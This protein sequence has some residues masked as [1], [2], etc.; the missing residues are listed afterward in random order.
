MGCSY[1][2]DINLYFVYDTQYKQWFSSRT[3]LFNE[4]ICKKATNRKFNLIEFGKKFHYTEKKGNGY[5]IGTIVQKRALGNRSYL[6]SIVWAIDDIWVDKNEIFYTTANSSQMRGRIFLTQKGMKYMGSY[7]LNDDDLKKF[8]SMLPNF[9]L[10]QFHKWM[11]VNDSNVSY[12]NELIFYLYTYYC[13]FGQV[14]YPV[15]GFHCMSSKVQKYSK[16][17]GTDDIIF[18]RPYIK[19]IPESLSACEQLFG[20]YVLEIKKLLY[21][22]RTEKKTFI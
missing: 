20:K 14:G 6:V 15:Q 4:A 9:Q 12:Q 2:R 21:D 3:D 7:W 8:R 1:Y 22:K 11:K 17:L 16:W 19:K 18:M 13:L 10:V 5:A